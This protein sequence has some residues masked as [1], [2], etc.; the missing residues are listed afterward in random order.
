MFLF[1][2]FRSFNI[3]SPLVFTNDPTGPLGSDFSTEYSTW[4]PFVLSFR[5]AT[6]P[7]IKK[8]VTFMTHVSDTI[9]SY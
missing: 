8:Y 1:D 4:V 7:L 3:Q 5:I 9:L 2:F 6:T